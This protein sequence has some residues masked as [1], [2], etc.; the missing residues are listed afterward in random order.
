M[1]LLRNHEANI[2]AYK[3]NQISNDFYYGLNKMIFLAALLMIILTIFLG[4]ANLAKHIFKN[5]YTRS[6]GKM[7]YAA[8]LASPIVI[9]SLYFG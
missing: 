1:A 9:T 2:D 5:H 6:F 7:A 3:W 8:G 4:H